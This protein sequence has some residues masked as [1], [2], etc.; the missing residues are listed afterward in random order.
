MSKL[1]IMKRIFLIFIVLVIVIPSVSAGNVTIKGVNFEIPQQYEHGTQKESS[2]VYESGFTFR[3]LNLDD[4][5]NL[6]SNFGSDIEGA[7]S[8]DQTNIAGHD[9]V[10]ILKEYN[11]KQYTTV[12]FATEDKIF[13]I[14]FNDTY[15]NDDISKIIEK[16]PE[17]TMSHDD[18]ASRLNKALNDYENQVAQE[19]ADL[20]QEEYQRN[21]KPTNRFFFWVR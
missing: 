21:N 15:V 3:I 20:R 13:L 10:V 18:F 19:K 9:A 2:Y 8:V 12:Y 16:T 1:I 17:Q 5:R 11:S 7:K 14:C 4:S 6:K